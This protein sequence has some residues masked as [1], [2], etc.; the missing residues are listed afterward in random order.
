MNPKKKK[1]W[2][3]SQCYQIF[4]SEEPPISQLFPF[5]LKSLSGKDEKDSS[6]TITLPKLPEGFEIPK[7]FPTEF[8]SLTAESLAKLVPSAGNASFGV[9]SG[10]ACGYFAK[11]GAKVAMVGFGGVF[12]MFQTAAHMG[13]VKVDMEKIENDMLKL[14][15]TNGDGKID[16]ADAKIWL[17]RTTDFL[18]FDTK[19]AAPSFATGFLLGLRGG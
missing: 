12:M 8:P 19:I 14:V 18:V 7:E 5:L 15:D 2:P 1:E 4:S 16:E 6:I 11:K 17:G 13:Y 10:Y 3:L 9:A